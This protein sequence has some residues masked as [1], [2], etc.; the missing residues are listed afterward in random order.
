MGDCLT[1]WS[2]ALFPCRVE[3]DSCGQQLLKGRRTAF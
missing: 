1:A 2:G 3:A